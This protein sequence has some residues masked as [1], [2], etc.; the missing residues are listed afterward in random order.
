M[1]RLQT[2]P[3]KNYRSLFIN[4][5]C[6]MCNKSTSLRRGKN[7]P[8]KAL[9]IKF[10]CQNCREDY[11]ISIKCYEYFDKYDSILFISEQIM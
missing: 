11:N 2:I 10:I 5:S 3:T 4:S 9:L 6:T 8:K 1:I 7:S